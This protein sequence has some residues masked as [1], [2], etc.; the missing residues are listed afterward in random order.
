MVEDTALQLSEETFPRSADVMREREAMLRYE[1]HR[2]REGA[3]HPL[4]HARPGAA[5]VLALAS[6]DIR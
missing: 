5:H 4:R 1:L 6:R 2:I 3:A